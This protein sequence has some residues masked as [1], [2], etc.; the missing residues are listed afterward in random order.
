[1]PDGTKFDGYWENDF[2][3]GKG[4]LIKPDGE[5]VEGNFIEN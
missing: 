5:I 4:K 1:M 3:H 2:Q